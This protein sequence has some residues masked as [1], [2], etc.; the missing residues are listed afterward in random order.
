M[1]GPAFTLAERSG[2]GRVRSVLGMLV[3]V[4]I[5][6]GCDSLIGAQGWHDRHGWKAADY[7]TDAKV[8]ELCDA[9]AAN[10]L[11]AIRKLI[12]AG[13]DVNARG[14]GNMTP[15]LW[16]FPDE[17]PERFRLL[18]EAGADP[19]V[20][21]ESDFGDPRAFQPGDTVT[22]M[23]SRSAFGHFWP[24]FEHG[25]DPNLPSKLRGFAGMTPV[26]FV[27]KS[28]ASDKKE[29]I[30]RLAEL[31]ASLNRPEGVSSSPLMTAHS[32]FGRH[33][34]CLLLLDL[35]AD[36]TAYEGNGV[37]RLTHNLCGTLEDK[38][39][40]FGQLHG[41]SPERMK[42][43]EELVERLESMGLSMAEAQADRERWGQ[44]SDLIELGK[45]RQ[46]EREERERREQESAAKRTAAA[47]DSD[48][49]TQ[50][51][52]REKAEQKR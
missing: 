14:K 44:A 10:D 4:L 13:A 20:Y 7:F 43:F 29:R 27:I 45:M 28:G 36:P 31:G 9:I 24:V 18:L 41:A 35:G 37:S 52:D 51:D 46:R 23:A 50:P 17:K 8:V 12:A 25:G 3:V 5:A 49:Q 48:A 26:Y 39:R 21:T 19:N 2:T 15:L 32:H 33:D 16:A 1:T 40:G 38:R 42:A 6:S 30:T 22:H 47:G 34:L 11:D